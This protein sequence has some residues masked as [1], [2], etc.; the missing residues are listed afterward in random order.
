MCDL[1]YTL[2]SNTEPQCNKGG[3]R[4]LEAEERCRIG[5]EMKPF[6]LIWLQIGP[7][8]IKEMKR[9]LVSWRS[10]CCYK[11]KCSKMSFRMETEIGREGTEWR[12]GG[13]KE[14]GTLSI[15]CVEFITGGLRGVH[16]V[17]STVVLPPRIHLLSCGGKCRSSQDLMLQK[18]DL[19]K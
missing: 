8:L 15:V 1:F 14:I 17:W 16:L 10:L 9:L 6:H 3:V 19:F 7:G 18:Y 13:K 4:L 5:A 12:C 11:H 2:V